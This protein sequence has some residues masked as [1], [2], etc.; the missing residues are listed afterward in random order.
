MPF[1]EALRQLQLKVKPEN[2]CL[3][4]ISMVPIVG[5]SE[6][7][8]T[9]PTQH[10]VK[11]LRSLGLAPDFIVCRAKTPVI[12]SAR[13]KIALFCNVPESNV[14][15]IHDVPNIYHV[16]LLM[17]QQ[18]FDV[19]LSQR[20]GLAKLKTFSKVDEHSFKASW[21]GMINMIDDA[22]TQATIALVGKYTDSQDAYVKYIFDGFFRSCGKHI[23]Y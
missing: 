11:E 10:S 12:Q 13:D 16:P 2:F 4:H 8:K 14:L 1:V 20:L 9:K 21:E 6:E 7:Q 5:D 22:E 18:S 23:L 15:S 17:I 19:L 3:V